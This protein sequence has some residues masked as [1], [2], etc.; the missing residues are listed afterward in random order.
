[1]KVQIEPSMQPFASA[2]KVFANLQV[3]I[4]IIKPSHTH[5]RR[6]CR[7][8]LPV[9]SI[10]KKSRGSQVGCERA[11][12]N[13]TLLLHHVAGFRAEPARLLSRGGCPNSAMCTF[14]AQ[15]AMKSKSSNCDYAIQHSARAACLCWRLPRH[16]LFCISAQLR[17]IPSLY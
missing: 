1:M 13:C 3:L 16:C 12:S 4:H 8:I 14:C 6:W 5:T 17:G 2:C 10:R 9:S 15:W 11:P 7:I